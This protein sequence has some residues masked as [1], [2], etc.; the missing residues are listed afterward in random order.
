MNHDGENW[1][2]EDSEVFIRYGAC[3]VPKREEHICA[4]VDACKKYDAPLVYDICC[5]GGEISKAI[6]ASNDSASL[7][8]LDNSERMLIET[9]AALR[10]F[11]NRARVEGFDLQK[12]ESLDE[13]PAPHIVLSSLAVHHLSDE[14][15]Q[16]LFM[17]LGKKI[18]RS[19]SF[20]LSDLF[21]P[22]QTD[23]RIIFAE[24][25]NRAVREASQVTFGDDRA[26][27]AFQ[28]LDWNHYSDPNPDPIDKPAKLSQHIEWLKAAGFIKPELL[29][30]YAGH[31]TILARNTA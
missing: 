16:E 3:F 22:E 29:V 15:K 31:G 1:Y 21:E 4:I 19:G 14:R 17:F 2:D 10:E 9:T 12:F 13:F 28:E 6:L 5:G 11:S 8:A 25:W 20:I 18:R 26:F 23:N 7:I 30:F 27:V 24:Q